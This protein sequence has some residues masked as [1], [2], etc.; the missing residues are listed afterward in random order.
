REQRVSPGLISDRVFR[1]QAGQ[2][3][4]LLTDLF[5]NQLF[6]AGS[7]VAFVEKQVERLQNT[8]QPPRQLLASWYFERYLL[9]ANFLFRAPQPLGN[10]RLGREKCPADFRHA[11][12]AKRP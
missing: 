5:S 8:V 7:F 12:A 9:F 3:N 10:R 6:T 2:A 11:E 4:R 1:Q